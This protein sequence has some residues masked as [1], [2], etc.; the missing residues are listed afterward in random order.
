MPY[1][2]P[3]ITAVNGLR[4]AAPAAPVAMDFLA[5]APGASLSGTLKGRRG[6]FDTRIAQLRTDTTRWWNE[7]RASLGRAAKVVPFADG[8]D[9]TEDPHNL[10]VIRT[11]GDVDAL[12]DEPARSY[13]AGY[14]IRAAVNIGHVAAAPRI[15]E[16]LGLIY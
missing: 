9:P 3:P 14:K 13:L 11:S 15:K 6:H 7:D 12:T 2:L 1:E 8:S 4:L 10:P 16:H 5:G